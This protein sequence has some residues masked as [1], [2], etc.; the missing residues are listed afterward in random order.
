VRRHRGHDEL[1]KFDHKLFKYEYKA[2]KLVSWGLSLYGLYQLVN[3]HV[4]INI[5]QAPPAVQRE[6]PAPPAQSSQ[7]HAP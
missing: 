3:Q 5:G 6:L 7:A 1:I 2:M 4:H